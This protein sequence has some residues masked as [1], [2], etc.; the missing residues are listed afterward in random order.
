ML[1]NRHLPNPGRAL[2]STPP[3]PL[4]GNSFQLQ[5]NHI[6]STVLIC[7]VTFYFWQVV[8]VLY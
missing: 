6:I 5:F 8:L 4:A 1:A 7:V 3:P 2:P